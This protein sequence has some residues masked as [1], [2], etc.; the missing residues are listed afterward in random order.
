MCVPESV[1]D[2]DKKKSGRMTKMASERFDMKQKSIEIPILF[3][4]LNYCCL[5]SVFK[6]ELARPTG[7]V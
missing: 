4:Y 2:L 7:V 6:W 1:G 5:T 3:K